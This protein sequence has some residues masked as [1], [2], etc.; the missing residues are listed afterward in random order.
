MRSRRGGHIHGFGSNDE[1]NLGEVHEIAKT[2]APVQHN[3][4][5]R[6]V[7]DVA[8]GCFRPGEFDES[9]AVSDED[10]ARRDSSSGFLNGRIIDKK[11]LSVA[12][13]TQD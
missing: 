13:W 5:T 1:T 4:L 9:A 7:C 6:M 12:A 2:A 11:V 10:V 8:V 3:M